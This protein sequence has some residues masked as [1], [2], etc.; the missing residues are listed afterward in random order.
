MFP[1][2]RSVARVALSLVVP[3]GALAAQQ[4]VGTVSGR[5]TQPGG[6]PLVAAQVFIVGSTL[7]TVTDTGGHYVI[8]RVPAGAHSVRVQRIGFQPMTIAV[9]V[10]GG[11]RH[12]V[13]FDLKAAV[14]ALDQVV[15]TGTAGAARMREVGNSISQIN[16]EKSQDIPV[17]MEALLTA[18]APGM[19]VMASSGQPGSAAQIRLRGNVSVA[20]SNQPLVYIDGVR[21]RSEPYSKNVS[22][23]ESSNRSNNDVQSPLNDLNPADIE[24]IEIIKG[25]AATTLY[26]TEANAGVIQIFT[27]RGATGAAQWSADVDQGFA[28][29][30]P[31]APDPAPYAYLDPWLKNGWRQKYG[32][33]VR[34]GGRDLSYFLSGL[35]EDNK[36]V[37]PSDHEGRESIRANFS[38]PGL[39]GLQVQ[40]NNF[41]THSETR[42]TPTGNN[43]HGLTLNV[44][45]GANNFFGSADPKL[46]SQVLQFDA[47]SMIDRFTTGLTLTY[48]PAEQWS[49]RL[50]F[51]YDMSDNELRSVR[52]FAFPPQPLGKMSDVM[53]RSRILTMDLVSTY[54]I[55]HTLRV[56]DLRTSLSAGAQAVTSDDHTLDGLS[57]TFP[58][59][60]TPTLSTGSIKQSFES[61]TKV[62]NGG[63]FAQLLL[64]YK[65]RY[66]LTLGMRV[67][68]NSAF[69]KSFGLQQYP[70]AS[71]TYVISDEG[72]WPE[73]AGTLKLRLAYGQAGRAPG[74]FDA[75]R[76]WD[77]IGWGGLPAYLPLNVGNPDLG[78]E[79]TAETEVGF[80]YS[81]FSGRLNADVTFYHQVTSDALFPVQQIPSVGFQ[82]SQLRNVGKMQNEGIEASL[83]G[84]V[85]ESKSGKIRWDLGLNIAKSANKALDLGGSPSFSLGGNGWIIKGQ[86]IPVIKGVYLTNPHDIANPITVAEHLFGPNTP[87]LVVGPSSTLEL[88]YGI[89]VSARGEYQGGNFIT[90]G[91]TENA[92]S[93][94]ITVW[95]TCIHAYAEVAAGRLSS[96][97]AYD[98]QFCIVAN[99][100]ANSTIYPADFFKLRELSV[101]VAV[102]RKW[103]PGASSAYLTLAARNWYRWLNS[104]FKMFDPEMMAN[105][106]ATSKVRSMNEQ[107]PAPAIYTSSFKIVF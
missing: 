23:G 12:E 8:L 94:G 67:D 34:G 79:R 87:T 43:S 103:I 58:G 40:W 82:G 90:D 5:V 30:Q 63:L 9:T 25:A 4:E 27:K 92:Q 66:F 70:K 17:N 96:L 20:M 51:G 50:T 78:P 88:P 69:G 42:T 81:V 64:N 89:T 104:D 24:R 54:N 41:L 35:L 48:A 37:L 14:L 68:G 95:P 106:G 80:D 57:E 32:L 45:R 100:K 18:Q 59:P 13:D 71:A 61:A 49:N 53:N 60:S 46:I 85:F 44:Y 26:G 36:G 107:Y 29:L 39:K 77:P 33:S 55:E 73:K 16:V 15:V 3:L 7:G 72:F 101:R 102:P 83:K 65:D 75:V 19:T 21:T 93:R 99:F 11:N 74:A 98:R 47:R 2:S 10:V 62:V 84:T 31:F 52:P 86:P 6:V 38:F 97:T 76:T 28:K 91:G 56:S 105:D 1:W 22:G